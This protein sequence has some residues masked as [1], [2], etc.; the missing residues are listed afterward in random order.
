[1]VH[2]IGIYVR[3]IAIADTKRGKQPQCEQQT[4]Q[5]VVFHYWSAIPFRASSLI[6][7]VSRETK[8]SSIFRLNGGCAN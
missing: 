6:K 7:S 1:M 8:S 2:R 4:L 5:P 3:Q